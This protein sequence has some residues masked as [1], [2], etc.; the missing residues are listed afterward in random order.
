MKQSR[1]SILLRPGVLLLA[2]VGVLAVGWVHRAIVAASGAVS[3]S[4]ESRRILVVAA[5][6]TP[7][8]AH[9]LHGTLV[10]GKLL[11][12]AHEAR[13]INDRNC[14]PDAKGIS[15]C[16][17]DLAV[18]ARRITIQH[19]H[20]MSQVPCLSPGETITVMDEDTFG[21]HYSS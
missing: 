18:G 19:H 16:L 1:R 21:E 17:N 11:D 20:R 12:G 6:D 2:L 10:T 15:H 5:E 7:S 3:P 9:V 13:V 14:T 8:T 4:D